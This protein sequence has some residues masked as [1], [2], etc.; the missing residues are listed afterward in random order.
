[1]WTRDRDGATVAHFEYENECELYNKYGV[2]ASLAFSEL[3]ANDSEDVVIE[4]ILDGI[5]NSGAVIVY[6]D[7]IDGKTSNLKPQDPYPTTMKSSLPTRKAKKRLR[8]DRAAT[9]SYTYVDVLG[10]AVMDRLASH[11]MDLTQA[12]EA[13]FQMN[14]TLGTSFDAMRLYAMA[15][16]GNNDGLKRYFQQQFSSRG[17]FNDMQLYAMRQDLGLSDDELKAFQRK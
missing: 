1:L 6:C 4:G 13:T 9:E 10:P 2:V 15:A 16:G 11:F 7:R 14:M 5:T 3:R 17:S 8:S 12:M